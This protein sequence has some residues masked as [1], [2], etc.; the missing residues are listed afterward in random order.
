[1]MMMMMMI[2]IRNTLSFC[3]DPQMR[4][5]TVSQRVMLPRH[6]LS[7]QLLYYK[8]ELWETT[9]LGWSPAV[10][11]LSPAPWGSTADG[12]EWIRRFV[13]CRHQQRGPD[14]GIR[15]LYGRQRPKSLCSTQI[16]RDKRIS[17]QLLL[18]CLCLWANLFIFRSVKQIIPYRMPTPI[19]WFWTMPVR[20]G[21]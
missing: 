6:G 16:Q 5:H 20:K 10:A 18:P 13:W 3:D 1:M 4:R 12:A 14:I 21:V 11:T 9:A 7:W 19:I 8:K 15:A 17:W 2:D